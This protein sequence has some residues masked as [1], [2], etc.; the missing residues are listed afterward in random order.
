MLE[1]K[2]KCIVNIDNK[3]LIKWL[4]IKRKSICYKY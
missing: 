3:R 1:E 4:G 2:L